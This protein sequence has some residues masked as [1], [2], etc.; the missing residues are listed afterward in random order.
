M[1]SKVIREK[2]AHEPVDDK[3]RELTDI[4]KKLPRGSKKFRYG[5]HFSVALRLF[6]SL[7][8]D[9]K[10]LAATLKHLKREYVLDAF[11]AGCIKSFTQIADK[12]ENH[13]KK[14][15]HVTAD[16]DLNPLEPINYQTI[17]RLRQMERLA[18]AAHFSE[19]QTFDVNR[20]KGQLTGYR[21]TRKR[22]DKLF[23]K[24]DIVIKPG[25]RPT[26]FQYA[27]LQARRSRAKRAHI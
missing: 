6:E 14:L 16:D 12:F 4:L 20:L 10:A 11:R 7:V 22:L 8:N 18:V 3:L 23:K 19:A 13:A 26:Q 5:A 9:D 1:I 24:D 15:A 17:R 25:G 2:I 21:R 27:Q